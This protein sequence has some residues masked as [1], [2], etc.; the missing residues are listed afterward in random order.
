MVPLL[1]INLAQ[2]TRRWEHLQR[3]VAQRLPEQT[4][5]RIDAVDWRRLPDNLPLTLF[6]QYLLRFPDVQ[7]HQRLSH[8]QIDTPSASGS[9]RAAT[10]RHRPSS[11][12]ILLSHV[13]CWEW[14]LAT[15]S[16]EVP[17]ALI[18]E[19]DACL[20]A[21]FV[22]AFRAAVLPLSLA[23]AA[24]DCLILGYSAVAQPHSDREALV[25][26]VRVQRPRSFFGAHA[27]CVTRAGARILLDHAFPM[28]HQAD[29]LFL[30]LS[31]LGLW[32]MYMLPHSVASQC[33]NEEDRQGS[34]H[35][36][37][38]VPLVL[39]AAADLKWSNLTWWMSTTA[40]CLMVVCL[41]Q[42]AFRSRT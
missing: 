6:S 12:A 33:I 10:N 42:M 2:A 35:T 11:V 37:V 24:W 14:L 9:V 39:T 20:G 41:L 36:H 4:L 16:D 22:E 28:D 30:T 32:R 40:A 8:R 5:H 31:D 13:R 19:D 21:D 23:T 29:G 38:K 27:Y 34:W 26:G 25:A 7:G 3:Q 15:E 18:L 17:C 1:C